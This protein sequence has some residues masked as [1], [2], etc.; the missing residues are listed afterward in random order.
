MTT[1]RRIPSAECTAFPW[2]AIICP[3]RLRS[4]GYTKTDQRINGITSAVV[5]P[6]LSR[7]SATI[8]LEDH[9]YRYGD[10]AIVYCMSGHES[11]DW[12]ALCQEP[13]QEQKK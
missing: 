7:E 9:R 3:D 4:S 12:R 10:N 13:T 6:F 11:P 8:Y 1:N 2:W 5:G